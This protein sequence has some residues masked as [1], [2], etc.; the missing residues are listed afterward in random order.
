MIVCLC[1]SW[2]VLGPYLNLCKG[3]G[4]E[5]VLFV[6]KRPTRWSELHLWAAVILAQLLNLQEEEEGWRFFITWPVIQSTMST[7]WN[8]NENSGHRVFKGAF[9]LVN[10]WLCLEVDMSW[11]HSES[12]WK[13]RIWDPLGPHLM[14]L[15]TWLVLICMLYNKTVITSIALFWVLIVVL[16]N[17][18]T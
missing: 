15:F 17:Y 11:F 16:A 3:D 8:S 12:S 7:Y 13:L 5:W 10:T 18:Q 4:S 9:W 1:Y 14:C 2:W 6:T